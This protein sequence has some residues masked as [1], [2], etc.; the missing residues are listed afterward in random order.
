[1]LDILKQMMV[2]PE[3]EEEIVRK[4]LIYSDD[5][6]DEE[7]LDFLTLMVENDLWLWM[8]VISF[9]LGMAFGKP[10]FMQMVEQISDRLDPRIAGEIYWEHLIHAGQRLPAEVGPTVKILISRK[11]GVSDAFASALIAGLMKVEKE[12]ATEL[13]NHISGGAGP[14]TVALRSI[15]ISTKEWDMNVRDAGPL[16]LSMKLPAHPHAQS[17]YSMALRLV[18][19]YAPEEVERRFMELIPQ[20]VDW[21]KWQAL[22]DFAAI[23]G[24]SDKS[25]RWLKTRYG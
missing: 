8:P 24:L 1:M 2:G 10:L 25:K 18:H 4:W 17:V 19:E 15:I 3:P 9:E 11:E 13:L 23:P 22:Y 12:K 21:V 7:R 20:A 6:T 5:F 16:V 14:I